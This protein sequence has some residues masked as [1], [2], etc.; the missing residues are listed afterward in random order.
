[1]KDIPVYKNV[2]GE[3]FIILG[4]FQVLGQKYYSVLNILDQIYSENEL[5]RLPCLQAWT[6]EKLIGSKLKGWLPIEFFNSIFWSA[7]HRRR[8]WLDE[9]PWKLM[10]QEYMH[11]NALLENSFNAVSSLMDRFTFF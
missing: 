7:Y 2:N 11:M 1:M 6:A 10:D 3:F 9:K 4:V 8:E 5:I